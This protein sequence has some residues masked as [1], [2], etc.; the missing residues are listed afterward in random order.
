MPPF[1][2]TQQRFGNIYYIFK[3]NLTNYSHICDTFKEA[4]SF[5]NIQEVSAMEWIVLGAVVI[6]V[7]VIIYFV[8]AQKSKW[9][10][11]Q[12]SRG[13]TDEIA[14]AY[15]HLLDQGIR[16]RLKETSSSDPA[17]QPG[18]AMQAGGG[19]KTESTIGSSQ[20]RLR[21]SQDDIA[22]IFIA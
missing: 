18:M 9:K 11:L 21:K 10:T 2:L 20:R 4:D 6:L 5:R 13:M 14:N 22:T 3:K 17:A 19:G 7:A 8:Y 15:S 16:C 12:E 1:F